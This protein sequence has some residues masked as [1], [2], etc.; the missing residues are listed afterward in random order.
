MSEAFTIREHGPDTYG[1]Y[2]GKKR[3]AIV[4]EC[5][6]KTLFLLA[7]APLLKATCQVSLARFS[8]FE[9]TVDRIPEVL[10]EMAGRGALECIDAIRAAN[11]GK[12]EG[13]A[14]GERAKE[15]QQ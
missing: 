13:G 1:L 2:D 9:R 4:S 5:D 6:E 11:G 3:V 8:T 15:G 12:M 7:S 14:A 10:R